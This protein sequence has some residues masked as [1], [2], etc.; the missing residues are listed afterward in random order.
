MVFSRKTPIELQTIELNKLVEQ[1]RSMLSRS[2]SKTI[3]IDLLLADD[4]WTIKAAPNQID[5]ILMNLAVNASDAMPDGGRLAIKT[6]NIVLDDEF[7]SAYPNTKPGRYA[8]ITVADTGAGMNKK[9]ASRIFEPFFTTKDKDK[10]T[11]LGLAVVY[12]IVEGHGGMICC[13]SEPS[14][15]TAFRIYFPAIEEVSEEQYSEKKE[16]P[17]G[18]GETILLV[19]DEPHLVDIVFRQLMSANYRVI[20]ASNGKEAL[21]HYEEHREQ[22]SLVILDLLM[23]EM[24]GKLCLEA[25]RELNPNVRVL[26]AS[27]ALNSQIEVDLTEIDAKRFIAKPFD[28]PQ[29]LEK[30]R[31]IIDEE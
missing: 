14:V 19:D 20:K 16:P 31:Q 17:R 23:P 29:L 26:I 25:L 4:L 5:Q 18:Q 1:T 3:E 7:C 8:L 11:G 15:G 12:G 30:I 22:I 24:S 13:D 10:G 6:D 21:S 2:I 27:G 28:T 9:T